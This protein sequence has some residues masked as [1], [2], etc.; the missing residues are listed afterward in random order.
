MKLKALSF[1]RR[2]KGFVLACAHEEDRRKIYS[3]AI[4]AGLYIRMRRGDR[5]DT[6]YSVSSINDDDE[7]RNDEIESIIVFP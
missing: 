7:L 6:N 2:R 4:P 3:G 1:S 5:S